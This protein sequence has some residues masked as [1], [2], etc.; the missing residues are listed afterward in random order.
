[1]TAPGIQVTG[2]RQV[3]RSLEKLGASAADLK[4][5]FKRIGT[6]VANEAKSIVPRRSGR[7]ADSIKPSNTK[8]K[9][10]VRAGGARVPYAGVIHFGGYHGI[11]AQPF[12]TEALDHKQGE[13]KR[14]MESELGALVRRLDLN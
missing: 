14:L 8:N 1:M 12:L 10:V 5:A 6:V 9:S 4:S 2:L 13:A 7:L 3:V 11:T